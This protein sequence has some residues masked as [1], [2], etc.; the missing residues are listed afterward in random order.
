MEPLVNI[1]DLAKWKDAWLDKGVGSTLK[2]R[3]RA[4]DMAPMCT[5]TSK[6]AKLHFDES[7]TLKM[8]ICYNGMT[9]RR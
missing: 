9:N 1:R 6:G 4:K 7:K 3:A 5:H 8:P 2:Q